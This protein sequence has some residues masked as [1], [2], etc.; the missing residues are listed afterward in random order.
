MESQLKL[1]VIDIEKPEE[2]NVILGQSHFIKTVEDLYE[3]LISCFPGIKF[4]FAFCE[5]SGD[6]LVRS[7]GT[8]EGL[9]LLAEKNAEKLG[10]GHSFII[11]L[12]GCYPIN[13]LDRVRSVPEVCRV[14]AAT[15]N[16]LG[17]VVAE[18]GEG[19]GILGVI[20]GKKP[21]G[22]ETREDKELRVDFLRQICYKR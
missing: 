7:D 13:V 19:R 12:S 20:D 3:A 15:A 10:C 17:V 8:D 9:I 2:L 11:F 16:S 1:E 18:A 14:I 6:C 5:A 4:G 22:I 21:K